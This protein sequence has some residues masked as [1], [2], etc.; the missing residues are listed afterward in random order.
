MSK[1]PSLS[2]AALG[3]S[4]IVVG[5]LVK[6][7]PLLDPLANIGFPYLAVMLGSPSLL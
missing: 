1:I 6:S 4:L 2:F 3:V 5:I 7:Y